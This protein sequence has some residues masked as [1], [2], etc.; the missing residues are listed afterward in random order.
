MQKTYPAFRALRS[1]QQTDGSRIIT[2]VLDRDYRSLDELEGHKLWI[3]GELC[4]CKQICE[5]AT[6]PRKKGERVMLKVGDCPE[7]DM[8]PFPLSTGRT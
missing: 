8:A 2:V 4:H 1:R 3:D 5:M 6:A 7:D